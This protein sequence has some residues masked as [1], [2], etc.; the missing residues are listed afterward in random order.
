MCGIF[1]SNRFFLCRLRPAFNSRCC[2]FPFI[3]CYLAVLVEFDGW[4]TGDIGGLSFFW[5]ISCINGLYSQS[6]CGSILYDLVPLR[7]HF[8]AVWT[9][10]RFVKH[11]FVTIIKVLKRIL[12]FS[13]HEQWPAF[14]DHTVCKDATEDCGNGNRNEYFLKRGH[15]FE[16]FN[17]VRHWI[18]I[19]EG[20][21]FWRLV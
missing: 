18:Y 3:F 11:Q 9:A 7:H 21:L 16:S 19:S 14:T 13:V 12:P 4:E 20:N 6:Q 2:S 10:T 5:I 15:G 17:D 1:E 8:D